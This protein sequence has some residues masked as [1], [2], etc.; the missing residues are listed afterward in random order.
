[1]KQ[2]DSY[3]E[4][5]ALIKANKELGNKTSNAFLLPDKL[6]AMISAGVLS[7]EQLDGVLLLLEDCKAFYRVYYYLNPDKELDP[8]SLDKDA[9]IEFPFNKE[10]N[11]KQKTQI[12]KITQLGFELGRES[13][14]M[15]LT[16]QN[17]SD[18]QMEY[19]LAEDA[20]EILAILN[21]AFDPLYAF[22]PSKEELITSINDQ[23]VLAVHKDGHVLAVLNSDVERNSAIIRHLAVLPSAR[24]MGLGASLVKS[25]L[26]KYNGSVK[27]YRH[28]VDVHNASALRLYEKSGYQFG[29]KR[30]NEYIRRK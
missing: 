23:K 24:G 30:A 8:V 20:D 12:E 17:D 6:K 10:L 26:V 28:W 19:A 5:T 27:D 18:A 14:E 2:L 3:E 9:V 22:L 15:V 13:A 11:D 25:F 21:D 16:E 29:I 4:Y 7:Y 1:M